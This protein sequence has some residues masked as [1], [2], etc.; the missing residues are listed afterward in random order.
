MSTIQAPP[1]YQPLAETDGKPTLPWILFFDQIFNGDNGTNWSPAFSNLT[2]VGIP[3]ITGRYYQLGASV[4]YFTINIAPNGGNTTATAG[5]TFV[6]NFPLKMAGNGICFAVS[7][8]LG[9][10]SGMVE[11]ASANIYVPAWNA[12]TVPLTIVG[13][14]EAS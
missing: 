5:T 2:S 3:T 13:I 1:I 7:G 8:L 11:L 4:A 12:V 14:V 10:N 9:T 6:S